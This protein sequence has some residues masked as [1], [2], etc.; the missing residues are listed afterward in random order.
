MFQPCHSY[1]VENWIFFVISSKNDL[2]K[3]QYDI[4]KIKFQAFFDIIAGH[5]VSWRQFVASRNNG[6]LQYII[7]SYCNTL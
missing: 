1:S 7:H 3:E 6:L 2:C 4:P 5:I